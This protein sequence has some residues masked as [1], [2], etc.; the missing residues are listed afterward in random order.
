MLAVSVGV[1]IGQQPV[2]MLAVC[3]KVQVCYGI[4]IDLKTVVG[5]LPGMYCL[6]ISL[7]DNFH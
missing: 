6:Y 4:K 7:N 3:A 2:A 1:W 5:I